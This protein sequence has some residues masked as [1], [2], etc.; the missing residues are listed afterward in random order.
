M[1]TE[2]GKDDQGKIAKA[3]ARNARKPS[4]AGDQ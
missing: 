1:R 3:K 2:E 4:L